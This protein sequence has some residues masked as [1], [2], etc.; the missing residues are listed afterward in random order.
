[1]KG[2]LR[3]SIIIAVYRRKDE[4]TALLESLSLQTDP[5][6][7]VVVVD[8]GSPE[9]LEPTVALYDTKLNIR[10]FY[11]K[12]SGPGKSRNYGMARA[13]GN[14][15]IFLDSDTT[16]PADYIAT[17]RSA[18]I[19]DYRDS[20]GGP[21]G[22]E[23]SFTALQKAISFSMTSLLTTGGIRGGK[24][25]LGRFQPRS[26]NMGLSKQAFQQS[27]G[28]GNLRIGEDPDLSLTL[29]ELG[30]ESKLIV[31]ARVYHKRRATLAK[32][33]R[34]VHEFGIARPI[35]NARHPGSG[36]LTFWLPTLFFIGVPVSVLLF[37]VACSVPAHWQAILRIPFSLVLFYLLLIFVTASLQHKQIKVGLLSLVTCCTQFFCYGYGFLKSWLKINILRLRPEKAFPGH[38]YSK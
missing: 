19:K 30:F 29:F 32:F 2:P 21:D 14:Y 16:A 36:K 23:D 22:A 24:R 12:N 13:S 9:P 4:I 38:F 15:F 25:H 5:D 6:F 20:Y 27:G 18:L 7:E 37:V 3:F 28:F 26:F 8:D 35:L 33:A 1:M 34:Q 31:E 17:V 11:K 10:Y